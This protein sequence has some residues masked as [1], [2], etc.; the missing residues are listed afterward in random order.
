MKQYARTHM[1]IHD[2]MLLLIT[3]K[4]VVSV[5]QTRALLYTSDTSF[6]TWILVESSWDRYHKCKYNCEV[7]MHV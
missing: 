4:L 7:S 3:D 5:L 6:K 2:Q 1:P